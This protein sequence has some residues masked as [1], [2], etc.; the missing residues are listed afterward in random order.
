MIAYRPQK[1]LLVSHPPVGSRWIHELKLDGFR[2]GVFLERGS[3]RVIS[4]RG[5]DYTL[6]FPEISASA[7]KLKAK[8]ALLDG[9]IVVLDKQGISRFQLLQQLGS[10]RSGLAFYAFDL[11]WLDGESL[12]K[13]PLEERKQALKKLVGRGVG[14]IRYTDHLEGQ[15]AEVFQQACALGA[16]GIISKVRD[17]PYRLGAR[18]SDWQKIKCIKRQEFVVGGFTDPSGA[19][20]GVG[21]IL[22]GYYERHALRFAGKVGTGAGWSN[23]FSLKLR[24]DLEKIEIDR[25]PFDPPPPGWL[26]RNAHWVKPQTVAEVEFTEWTG[27]GSIRHPSLQGFRTDKSPRDVHRER[28]AQLVT[29]DSPPVYPRLSIAKSDLIKLYSEIADWV[30]P[31]LEQRPLTLVK[32]TAPITRE[33][34]LRSQAKFIHH[35]ARD[36]RFVPD[37]VPRT[38]I[39]EKKKIG[40][41]CYI[42]SRSALL[43]LI[44]AEVIELHAWNA[45]VDDV[46]RPDRVVF[47]IDPGEGVAWRDIVASARRLRAIL[48]ERDLESWVKTTGDKGLHV[49][50]PFRPEHDWD[51]VF[52]FSRRIATELTEESA[53]YTLSF[54]KSA[55]RGR[56]LIDYKRNYRTSIAVAA[57]STRAVPG[58]AMSVPVG[59]EELGRLKSSG[60]FSVENIQERLRRLK[61]DPWKGYFRS[62]QRLD[63]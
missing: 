44:D 54:E 45:R 14:I 37:T 40:E 13:Q 33:D 28:E 21:S 25:T 60:A 36:Q 55:R 17:A 42:D 53:R 9:E 12:V 43:A 11:L 8:N 10:N 52:D 61:E 22:V 30:L 59:W 15:G 31:H 49:V 2:M 3:V 39:T 57:F 56:I 19:R 48:A 29:P 38:R 51:A 41:Y 16:E 4:R 50:V 1:A 23:A 18:S 62:K 6:E 35:T 63:L 32:M 34:A 24:R 5:T 27:D 46:E 26:G 58:G 20:V 7:K 47:D